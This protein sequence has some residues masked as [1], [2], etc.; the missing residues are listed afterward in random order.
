MSDLLRLRP[1]ERGLFPED[2]SS[3]R[4]LVRNTDGL[5]PLHEFDTFVMMRER[6]GAFSI[7]Q[8]GGGGGVISQLSEE[9]PEV[10]F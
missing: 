8:K 3:I 5:F 6:K 9:E 1:V 10:V 2:S 4:S 7:V